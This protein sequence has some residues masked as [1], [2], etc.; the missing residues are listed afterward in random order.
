MTDEELQQT[1]QEVGEDIDKLSHPD[2]PLTKEEKRR[3]NLL[4]LQKETLQQ[5]REAREKHNATQELSLTVQYG[6]LSSL[7]EKH[8]FLLHFLSS[9][10]RM[11]LF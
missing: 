3:Q 4:S 11:N 2:K 6:L 10:F 8:P 5:I 7:G 1:I 9:K